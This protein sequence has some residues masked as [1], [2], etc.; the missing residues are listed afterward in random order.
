MSQTTNVISHGS[1]YAGSHRRAN[2]FANRD[3]ADEWASQNKSTYNDRYTHFR[4]QN[5]EAGMA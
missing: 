3:T 4:K 1:D 5:N 2:Q